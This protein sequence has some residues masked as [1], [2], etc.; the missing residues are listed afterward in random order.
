MKMIIK[1]FK[2]PQI[3]SGYMVITVA[4][5]VYYIHAIWKDVPNILASSEI[6]YVLYAFSFGCLN[7]MGYGYVANVLYKKLGANISYW[8]T[9]QIILAS[10]LGIYLPGK[11]WYASNFYLF[12]RKLNI[13]SSIIAQSFGLSNVFLFITGGICSLPI[14]LPLLSYWEKVFIIAIICVLIMFSHPQ[15]IKYIISFF[16]KIN[17]VLKDQIYFTTFTS[18]HY[19]RFLFYFFL[20]W[21][22]A[23]VRLYFCV[24]TFNP[25]PYS[26]FVTIITA[27]AASLILG[28]LAIFAPGGIGIREG[29]GVFIL[30]TIIPIE[31]AVFVMILSRLLSAIT[32]L[33]SGLI[34][35]YLLNKMDRRMSSKKINIYELKT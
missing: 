24:M 20:L 29:V 10:R 16:P 2:S 7:Y 9:L 21:I 34:A 3:M 8:K 25:V 35:F 22:I 27:S 23:G 17:N 15:S 19:L 32:D 6:D 31:T 13:S 18:N 4:F 30:S 26:D 1:I 5:V 11:I 28:M 14:V 12:S 33:G